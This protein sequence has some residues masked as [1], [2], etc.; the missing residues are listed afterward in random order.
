[1][2][3]IPGISNISKK[4]GL[5]PD[6]T[7]E[8]HFWPCSWKNKGFDL[9]FDLT[10]IRPSN[11]TLGN[12]CDSSEKDK[13]GRSLKDEEAALYSSHYAFS[14]TNVLIIM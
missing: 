2:G 13:A 5:N 1:M 4:L 10:W 8:F 14:L 9:F 11:Q 7:Q 3:Q 12:G 6:K